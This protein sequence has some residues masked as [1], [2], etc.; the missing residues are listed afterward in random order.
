[1]KR[2][3]FSGLKPNSAEHVLAHAKWRTSKGK[4]PS[5]AYVH[6]KNPIKALRLANACRGLNII[7]DDTTPPLPEC[8]GVRLGLKVEIHR[9]GETTGFCIHSRHLCVRQVGV[10]GTVTG[11]VS[12]HGGDVWWV[13]H[14][15]GD[16]IGAYVVTEF[17]RRRPQ[18][19]IVA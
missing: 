2:R 6:E 13:K 10:L 4:R 12:G 3:M 17:K 7:L 1:M 14:D 16:T 11:L 5:M 15:G 19:A 8:K 9:L 18:K